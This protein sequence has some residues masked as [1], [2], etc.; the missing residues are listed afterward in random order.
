MGI[1]RS[2]V[3]FSTDWSEGAIEINNKSKILRT[4]YKL[5]LYYGKEQINIIQILLQS[6][7]H[8]FTSTQRKTT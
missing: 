8:I 4:Y 3:L 1:A 6:D 5:N 7:K 2:L